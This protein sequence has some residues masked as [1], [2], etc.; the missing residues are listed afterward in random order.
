MKK[1]VSIQVK[2]MISMFII[3]AAVLFNTFF[4]NANLGNIEQSAA[5]MNQIY[6]QIQKLYGNIG[7]R[8]EMIQ[9]YANILVGS[10]DDDLVIAG[11]IYGQLDSEMTT[12]K[13][14]LVELGDYARMTE[15]EEL[16]ALFAQY[17]DGCDV[18]LDS[19][20][21]LSQIRKEGD[22]AGAKMYLG[23]EALAII[24]SQEQVCIDLEAAFD[25][26][27][28]DAQK[29]LEGRINIAENSSLAVSIIS[30]LS[31]LFSLIMCYKD[32]LQPMK[33]L[34]LKV[35]QIASR[36]AEGTC[37]LTERMPTRRND[38]I[39]Q[40]MASMNLLL[41]AFLKLTYKVQKTT[42]YMEEAAN[43]TKVQFATSN[44]KINDL[45]AVMEELSAGS[46]EVSTLV[47][48]MK[49]KMQE[50][51]GQTG[52]ITGEVEQGSSFAADLRERA[53]Y[54]RSKT[55]E[56]RKNSENMVGTIKETMSKS[57][58][59]SHSI[60]RVNELTNTILEIASQTNLLALNAA[61][62]AARAGEAGKGFAVVAEEIRALADNSKTNASAIQELNN[63][64]IEIVQ[65][66]CACS[67]KML[68][69]VDSDIMEDYKNFENMSI[70]YADD[71]D[72][73]SQI[74]EKIQGSVDH[75]NQQIFSVTQN[76]GGISSS[77]EESTQGIQNVA[78]NVLDISN[79]TNE[80]YRE[81]CENT[82]V[83]TELKH[84]SAGFV[85]E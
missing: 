43:R 2:V 57:I 12:V 36:I 46:E 41:E 40:L 74:M 78:Q 44:D 77:M 31:I 45:S 55:T 9:K 28:A 58:E 14:L 6:V 83:T 65:S 15:N 56:S 80:I 37:D 23:T 27:L 1:G 8:V 69:F 64:I 4:T 70:Q 10:S 49:G 63:K 85:V 30:I 61:I 84:V 32:M 25:I 47:N 17:S 81:T 26:C 71:A 29:S 66:L 68:G 52:D 67:E 35:Q 19:M 24:L 11:D 18:L 79:T 73:V 7:K 33:K 3:L 50:I 21:T 53:G 38:E 16:I 42:A 5:Q 34:S 76:I 62:E 59:E 51:A 54:I 20:Q 82:K 39:G 13:G 22:M 48:Q 75:I 72:A 60:N